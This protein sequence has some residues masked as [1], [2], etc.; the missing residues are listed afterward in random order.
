MSGQDT[1]IKLRTQVRGGIDIHSDCI[2]KGG[3]AGGLAVLK[4]PSEQQSVWEPPSHRALLPAD[5]GKE[6]DFCFGCGGKPQEV[7]GRAGRVATERTPRRLLQP[8]DEKGLGECQSWKG[9]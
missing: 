4:A 6:L 8:S 1:H 3:Q 5:H 2:G 9:A 7:G